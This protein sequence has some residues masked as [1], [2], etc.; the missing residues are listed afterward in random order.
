M[1]S[2]F[3]KSFNF[4]AVVFELEV[5]PNDNR[6]LLLVCKGQARNVRYMAKRYRWKIIE[7]KGK[8]MVENGGKHYFALV[9]TTAI[10]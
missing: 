2:L 1:F 5:M 6:L 8:D 9:W 10:V 7:C 4:S 3:S